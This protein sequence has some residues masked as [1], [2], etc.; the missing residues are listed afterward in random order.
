[1]KKF[2]AILLVGAVVMF[3]LGYGPGDLIYMVPSGG[4]SAPP[5]ARRAAPPAEQAQAAPVQRSGG[6]TVIANGPD[7]SLEHRWNS[8]SRP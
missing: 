6:P 1:M 2:A 5:K 4:G 3:L 8:P 7:G